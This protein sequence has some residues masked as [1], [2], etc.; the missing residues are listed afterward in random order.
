M[1]WDSVL[2]LVVVVLVAVIVQW[3]ERTSG[4]RR[5]LERQLAAMREEYEAKLRQMHEQVEFLLERLRL[6]G[7]RINELE[8]RLASGAEVDRR[9]LVVAVASGVDGWMDLALLRSLPIS[10]TRLVGA[11]KVKLKRH[12]DRA[13]SYGRPVAH[14]HIG[15][16]SGADGIAL[17]DGL[18]D[19]D[20]LS[21]HL[22][23]V[24]V[25]LLA[26]CN[27]D[28]LG[29]WLASVPYVVTMRESVPADDAALFSKLF[30]SEIVTGSNPDEALSSALLKAPAGMGEYVEHHW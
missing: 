9:S 18:A 2:W 17:D 24:Q 29:D 30:W 3:F 16:H 5:S 7:I 4:G 19:A 13:R 6:D 12:L 26:G 14:L 23:G 1:A 8:K 10:I 15:A 21:Q 11:T 27:G 25:L 20:W 22:M 28:E